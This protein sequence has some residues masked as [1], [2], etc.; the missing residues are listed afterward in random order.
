MRSS[1]SRSSADA[2]CAAPIFWKYSGLSMTTSRLSSASSTPV[3]GMHVNALWRK[4]QKR[5]SRLMFTTISVL[6][7]QTRFSAFPGM[8]SWFDWFCFLSRGMRIEEKGIY[9][10]DWW[11]IG[12][13]RYEVD[14]ASLR[15]S[16]SQDLDVCAQTLTLQMTSDRKL[17]RSEGE[18][19][20]ESGRGRRTRC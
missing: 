10:V 16:H 12:V 20:D 3:P 8:P 18:E 13:Q 1:S 7:R 19:I 2:K 4:V 9:E 6:P 5:V 14:Q 17:E 15:I 11:Y